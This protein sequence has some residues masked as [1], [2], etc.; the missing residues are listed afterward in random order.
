M[1]HRPPSPRKEV[2]IH[3]AS[4]SW[5]PPCHSHACVCGNSRAQKQ[6]T[7]MNSA[8]STCLFLL[9]DLGFIPDHP[10]LPPAPGLVPPVLEPRQAWPGATSLGWGLGPCP[11]LWISVPCSVLDRKPLQPPRPHPPTSYWLLTVN[12]AAVPGLPVVSGEGGGARVC[13]TVGSP[14]T[15]LPHTLRPQQPQ[16]VRAPCRDG[17]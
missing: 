9:Q 7:L 15:T 8:F 16:A 1:G 13:R 11:S 3:L 10:W 12:R 5:S 14:Q 6:V 2:P 17:P 4:F